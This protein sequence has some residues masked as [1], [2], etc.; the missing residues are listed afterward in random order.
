MPPLDLRLYKNDLRKYYKEK[1]SKLDKQKKDDMDRQITQNVLK[2]RLYKNAKKLLIYVSTDIEVN[3][4][5]IISHAFKD[6]KVVAVPRCIPDTRQM[7][8]HIIKSFDDLEPSNYSLYEPKE[9]LPILEDFNSSIMIVPALSIDQRGYR[10]GYGKG[11]YDRY[12]VKYTG[13]KIGLCYSD[14]I[15]RQLLYGRYDKPVDLIVT[16]KGIR[17]PKG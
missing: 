17:R 1:R 8:F 15:R 12:L 9:T 16:E 14:D 7:N 2:L 4:R 11:Y 10:L 13:I 3:T 5:D 6:G